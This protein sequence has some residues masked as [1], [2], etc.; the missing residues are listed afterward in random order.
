M[1]VALLWGNGIAGGD[2][3]QE[4]LHRTRLRRLQA[5][6]PSS[7]RGLPAWDRVFRRR[8]TSVCRRRC[9]RLC[10]AAPSELGVTVWRM[11]RAT[12]EDPVR[13]LV[14]ETGETEEWTAE[15]IAL[16]TPLSAGERVRISVES[17]RE[18]HLYVVDRERYADGTTGT[19]LVIF[20]TSHTRSGCLGGADDLLGNTASAINRYQQ[21]LRISAPV[22]LPLVKDSHETTSGNSSPIWRIGSVRLRNIDSRW[23]CLGK[24][25]TV[26]GRGWHCTTSECRR[27]AW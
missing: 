6:V 17:P 15:R 2:R 16:G 5:P 1:V 13:L 20:P 27:M 3:D 19:P 24:Q 9:R 11:R 23:R 21:A 8:V 14:H 25:V 10:P 4:P 22:G 18:G 12:A 7:K 26:I